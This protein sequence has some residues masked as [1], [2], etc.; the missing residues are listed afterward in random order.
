MLAKD[1]KSR[2]DDSTTV[3]N[4]RAPNDFKKAARTDHLLA[5]RFK[6]KIH[7]ISEQSGESRKQE[8]TRKRSESE[9]SLEQRLQRLD[10]RVLE[11]TFQM[12]QTMKSM[13][14]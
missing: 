2:W 14:E 4:L 10:E 8:S 1:L 3:T 5:V 7:K 13:N 6:T 11:M 9:S 12:T